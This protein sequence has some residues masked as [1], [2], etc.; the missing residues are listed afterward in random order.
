MS[1]DD[2]PDDD[3]T[4][5]R[6][7]GRPLP[8]AP[9]TPTAD[10]GPTVLL[11][12]GQVPPPVPPLATPPTAPAAALPADVD[13]GNGLP[14]GTYLGE[15]ELTRMVGEGGFGIVYEAYDHS[16]Q[17]RVALKEYM[18]SSL[19]AR[20]TQSQVSVKSERHRETFQ[21]G[22]KSFINEAR[23]LASFDHPA[24]V[25]VY[26]FWEAN[27]TAYMVMPFLEG[28]TLRD[29]LRELAVRPDE[30]WLHGLLQPV[31][32]ALMVIHAEQCYHRDIAPDNIM[33]IAG[34]NR[35]LVL[36]FGAARRVIGDM[37]Q[38]LTV[39]LK[40]GYA[41]VEQYAEIPGLKQGAWTDV[42]ALAAVVYAAIMGRTPPPSVGRLLNDTYVPLAQ[43]AAG[44]YSPGFLE[45]VDRALA[46]R[47]EARTPSI[48][49]F[50]DELG[51]R[52]HN[53]LAA[54]TPYSTRP[55]APGEVPPRPAEAPPLG[56]PAAA[57]GAPAAAALPLPQPEFTVQ[58][59]L[60]PPRPAAPAATPVAA[61]APAAVRAGLSPA[62]LL[63]GSAVALA[64]AGWG[65]FAWLAPAPRVPA[66]SPYGATSASAPPTGVAEGVASGA[67][68][69]NPL[70]APAASVAAA[71]PAPAPA[72]AVANP[73][74][75]DP[76]T[77]FARVVQAG[78]FPVKIT[79]DQPRLRIGR[80]A[81]RFTV[82]A[83]REGHL[84]VFASGADGAMVQVVP[85]TASG[86][87]VLKKGQKFRFPETNGPGLDA[88]DPPGPG[89]VLAIVSARPRDYSAFN[90]KAMDLLRLFP[91]G[92]EGA[93]ALAKAAGP[94]PP[95]AGRALCPVNPPCDTDYGAA[96]LQLDVV[97]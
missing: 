47:P 35:W 54:Y 9:A 33:Q 86:Q 4:V 94:Q 7:A 62:V 81:V 40:P 79:T 6:P 71:T 12:P 29:R 37:T 15:F 83:E 24:L 76:F 13:H 22:L 10:P 49:Q 5:I 96:V 73:G 61:P 56:A 67:T 88:A 93:A 36:D 84:Y 23:L 57:T 68:A 74:K 52:G 82:E 87:V 39:I 97:R 27:G 92:A 64:L 63:G 46:V 72:A 59:A 3:R 85:H 2:T 41:P 19:A 8:A 89:Q 90:A 66:G 45:A 69:G 26:R 48:A 21:A 17:R 60:Q 20:G 14:I 16:L 18:P 1:A 31:T 91:S 65:L 42:Y 77:E 51:L 32:E 58:P 53:P 75:L 55:M 43:A 44:R 28:V 78:A 30:A 38:A 80:D 25:K 95:L 34:N 11:S 70:P 50:R